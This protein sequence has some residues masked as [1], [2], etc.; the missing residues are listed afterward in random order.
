MN[1]A[2]GLRPEGEGGGRSG[3]AGGGR[4]G[5]ST[6]TEGV[7]SDESE[8]AC[9]VGWREA[10]TGSERTN[11]SAMLLAMFNVEDSGRKRAD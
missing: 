9:C 5:E 10:D 6:V 11:G 2:G 4:D 3:R 7:W 8:S 1:P